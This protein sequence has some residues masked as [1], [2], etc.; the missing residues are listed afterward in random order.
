MIPPL[1]RL[2]KKNMEDAIALNLID[3]TAPE[4]QLAYDAIEMAWTQTTN[5]IER[6]NWASSTV[7]TKLHR[8]AV[9][10]N[11]FRSKTIAI[12]RVFPIR[13]IAYLFVDAL[14][15]VATP[16]RLR[17]R[18]TIDDIKIACAVSV[19][20]NP[21]SQ[22]QSAIDDGNDR[23][24]AAFDDLREQICAVGGASTNLSIFAKV[25]V[26]P[27]RA[28]WVGRSSK[29]SDKTSQHWRDKLGLEHYPCPEGATWTPMLGDRLVKAVFSARTSDLDLPRTGAQAIIR[30]SPK[31]VWLVRPTI[32]HEGN[33]RFVQRHLSDQ[34]GMALKQGRTI[35][36]K[37][38]FYNQGERELI[39]M[40]GAEAKVQ[41]LDAELLEGLPRRNL[42]D[43]DHQ[44]FVNVLG[45]RFHWQP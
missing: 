21:S 45:G 20:F 2:L 6:F 36:I 5:E 38:D 7:A 32:G 9:T 23:L 14:G 12:T 39:L 17:L 24:V 33:T 1:Q 34:A 31:D 30:T 8:A 4:I 44:G 15:G 11:S 42:H 37:D 22:E 26:A 25:L 27:G 41:W 16:T 19:P 13:N 35:D 28:C 18:K 29:I 10:I 3:S 40:F 43:T